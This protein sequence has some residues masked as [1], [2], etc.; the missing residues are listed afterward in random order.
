MLLLLWE[1]CLYELALDVGVVH[2]AI[3]LNYKTAE[4]FDGCL[5]IIRLAA[6]G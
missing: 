3:C 5:F 6:L 2:D 1:R 4:A